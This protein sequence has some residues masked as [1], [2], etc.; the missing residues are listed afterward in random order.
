MKI[1]TLLHE[2]VNYLS[3]KKVVPTG[4]STAAWIRSG[5][6]I[7]DGLTSVNDAA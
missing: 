4:N 3:M 5:L 2:S 6:M 7:T 1:I